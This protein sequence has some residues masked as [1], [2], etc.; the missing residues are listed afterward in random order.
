MCTLLD[1]ILKTAAWRGKDDFPYDSLVKA[2]LQKWLQYTKNKGWFD[3]YLP[4]LTKMDINKRDEALDE[5]LAAYFLEEKM[6]FVVKDRDPKGAN[7]KRGEFILV[8]EE[9][10]IFCEVKSPGWES[11]IVKKEG[12]H[13]SRLSTSK[14]LSVEARWGD[15]SAAIKATVDKAYEKLP[16]DKPSLLIIVDDFWRPLFHPTTFK[17]TI[18]YALYYE[19]I[20][21]PYKDPPS[22]CFAIKDY[23]NL[24][25]IL[26]LK[27]QI[28]NNDFIYSNRLC[29]NK[30][31]LC[32]FPSQLLTSLNGKIL[33]K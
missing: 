2:E 8:A 24:S 26:F 3:E 31:A 21:E 30:H 23:K 10:D 16:N 5:I 13:S 22:G 32:T 1:D 4:R 27:S 17:I 25:G 18:Y 6:H 15:D 20:P 12:V 28:R 29:L 9:T 11:E 19:T 14:Y 33:I 7:G